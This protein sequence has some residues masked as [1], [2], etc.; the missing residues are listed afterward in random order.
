MLHLIF[1]RNPPSL[2]YHGGQEPIVHLE[3]D[4]RQ[5][6]TWA[7]KHKRR[8]VSTL[9]NTGAYYFEDRSS[10]N[11]LSEIQWHAVNAKHIGR[12]LSIFRICQAN[13]ASKTLKFWRQSASKP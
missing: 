4:L 2:A 9:S 7:D 1:K 6:V 5:T 8:W 10:L 12:K 13:F 11:Q 3:A